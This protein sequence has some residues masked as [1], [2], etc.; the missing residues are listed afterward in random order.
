MFNRFTRSGH[1][2]GRLAL[3]AAALLV[4]TS[5]GASAGAPS[6]AASPGSSTQ[7]AAPAVTNADPL[8]AIKAYASCMRDQGIDMPDPTVGTVEVGSVDAGSLNVTPDSGAPGLTVV[9]GSGVVSVSAGSA[10]VQGTDPAGSADVQKFQAAD[11]ACR[12]FLPAA[13]TIAATPVDPA[14]QK[15]FTDYT[16][17]MRQHGVDMPDPQVVTSVQVPDAIQSTGPATIVS[18][19]AGVVVGV[20]GVV[21]A[22]GATLS[23]P[24]NGVDPQKLQAADEACRHFLPDG[25]AGAAT[26]SV[27][28]AVDPAS[29]AAFTDFA[30]CM[31]EH[32]V[33][34][35]DP[36][37]QS[38]GGA[39]IVVGSGTISSSST[40]SA[41]D[42]AT[43][44]A[45]NDACS[46]FLPG[47]G[48][49]SGGV[50]VVGSAPA[51]PVPAATPKP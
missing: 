29:V 41:A 49:T 32:G 5:A 46:H 33:D 3:L 10:P 16:A 26:I 43:L 28:T 22:S 12:H 37:V 40:G 2:P 42:P 27:S 1:A 35:P 36:Q 50:M 9:S 47:G 51:E 19:G 31:R 24:A 21:A 39:S 15:A 48:P 18:G 20:G 34:M 38:T 4:T 45:A 17:C 11:Q 7:S 44:T 8:S 14:A 13:T 6:P 30:K 23:D 25:G